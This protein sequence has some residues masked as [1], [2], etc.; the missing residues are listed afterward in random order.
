[1]YNNIQ[2]YSQM[3]NQHRNAMTP[4]EEE[5]E[6]GMSFSQ[7]EKEKE[8]KKDETTEE[9]TEVKNAVEIDSSPYIDTD[10]KQTVGWKL[11]QRPFKHF[12]NSFR[13]AEPGTV[14][15]GELLKRSIKSRHTLMISL[16]TGVGTGLLVGTGPILRQAGPLGLILGYLV[17]SI[18]VFL[19]MEAGSEL[20]IA[21]SGLVANFIRY[22]SFLVDPALGFSIAIMYTIEWC[23]GLPLQLVTA[24]IVLKF[25]PQLDVVNSNWFVAIFFILLIAINLFGGVRGYVESEFFCNVLRMMLITGFTILGLVIVSG[26]LHNDEG[27][28]GGR[29]WHDPGALAHGFKGITAVFCYA[30]FS[31]GG[32]ETLFLTAAEQENPAKSI[33][34]DCKKVLY[35]ILFIYLIPLIIVGLLV[36]YNDPHLLSSNKVSDPEAG[37]ETSSSTSPFVLA[38]QSHGVK[39][40][41]HFINFIILTSVLSVANCSLYS[42][43]RLLLSLSEQ[44]ILPKFLNYVD[45]RGRPLICLA[46]VTLFGLIG[47]VSDS[48]YRDDIFIW[49]LAIAGLA[50]IF[51]WMSICISHIRFRRAMKAQRRSLGEL[52]YRAKLGVIG[53]WASVVISLLLLG[54]Q[55]WVAISPVDNGKPGSLDVESFFQN[56]LAFPIILVI[57]LGYKIYH[58]QWSFLIR[59]EDVDLDNHRRVFTG[60]ESEASVDI[61]VSSK[62]DE[63]TARSTLAHDA[64]TS[65]RSSNLH[66]YGK[67]V[68]E[69]WC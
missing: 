47:F 18:M 22:P 25:W 45:R 17:S 27:Y 1:M 48:K 46:V 30:A 60:Q 20:A 7:R 52:G 59:A 62:D 16:G 41:P 26:G 21:Y 23:I 29:Y 24:V 65:H 63:E 56:Y 3:K 58:N 5:N 42:V 11:F 28:I 15:D 44:G 36:P 37:A 14:D 35:R 49:L 51:I 6:L 9:I 38:V 54:C 67:K 50:Q 31:Y 68:Y 39:V 57:Y 34:R 4:I 32:I 12:T 61:E 13:K 55:F 10:E 40:V 53:S 33:P 8:V 66:K 2:K 64:E 19:T 69:F 43:P